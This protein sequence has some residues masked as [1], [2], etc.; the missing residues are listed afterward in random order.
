MAIQPLS[1]SML[2]FSWF[3]TMTH[4]IP[5]TPNHPPFTRFLSLLLG[6]KTKR[7]RVEG[8]RT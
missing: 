3:V 8:V 4:D 5:I 7:V 6:L 2:E 1:Q